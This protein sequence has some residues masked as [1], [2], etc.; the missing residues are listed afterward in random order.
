MEDKELIQTIEGLLVQQKAAYD[1]AMKQF[2]TK[3]VV[4]PETKEQI[5]RLETKTAEI[6]ELKTAIN[7]LEEKA[8]RPAAKSAPRTLGRA[9][10]ESEAF[11]NANMSGRFN[12]QTTI[13]GTLMERKVASSTILESAYPASALYTYV[14]GVSYPQQLPTVI[15]SLLTVTAINTNAVEWVQDTWTLQADY[16]LLE[17]DKKATSLVDYVE[18]TSTVKTIAHF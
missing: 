16:Q 9:I 7:S 18:K 11:K 4:D 15:R 17:G 3:N 5:A 10:I 2:E 12:I 13:P 6:V 14:G 1:A 8:G